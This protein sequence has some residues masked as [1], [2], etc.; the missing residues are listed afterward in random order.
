M[1]F[2]LGGIS[3]PLL[4]FVHSF[5]ESSHF[6]TSSP[7]YL[8]ACPAPSLAQNTAK[9]CLCLISLVSQNNLYFQSNFFP[10]FKIVGSPRVHLTQHFPGPTYLSCECYTISEWMF[11]LQRPPGILESTSL[12]F[13]TS[14]TKGRI[15]KGR[16]ESMLFSF[17][18]EMHSPWPLTHCHSCPCQNRR[19]RKWNED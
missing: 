7:F 11:P 15:H 19:N 14:L 9:A 17:C 3:F 6:L 18:P 16:W 2:L 5:H 1:S 13:C 12:H 4:S 10:H 8:K